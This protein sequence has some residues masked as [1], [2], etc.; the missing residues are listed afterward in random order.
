MK[1]GCYLEPRNEPRNGI[2]SHGFPREFIPVTNIGS[3]YHLEHKRRSPVEGGQTYKKYVT[4]LESMIDVDNRR[5]VP[6]STYLLKKFRCHISV[7]YYA[8]DDAVKHMLLCIFKGFMFD[9]VDSN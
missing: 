5:V 2:C 7:K 1:L 6:H 4:L 8:Y 9:E 3:K